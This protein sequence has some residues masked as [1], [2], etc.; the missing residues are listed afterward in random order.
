MV[1]NVNLCVA[2]LTAGM[3]GDSDEIEKC[4]NG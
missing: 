1:V 2:V 3:F 4:D